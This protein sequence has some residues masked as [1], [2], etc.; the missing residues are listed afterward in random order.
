ML[1]PNTPLRMDVSALRAATDHID[2]YQE[3]IYAAACWYAN[4]GFHIVPFR[5]GNKEGKY[6]GFPKVDP[7]DQSEEPEKLSPA[8]ATCNPNT[9]RRWWHP[10]EGQY[11]GAG[12]AMAHGGASGLCALDLDIDPDKDIDGPSTLAD[13]HAAY[14]GNWDDMDTEDAIETLAAT[15]PSGGRHLVFRYHPE[16]GTDAN[17]VYEGIDTRGGRKDSPAENG[18][19]TF[20]E[21]TR[22]PGK[23]GHYRWDKDS[24]D[25]MDPPQWLVDVLNG[26]KPA[27]G[28]VKLPDSFTEGNRDA[29]INKALMSFVGAGYTEEQLWALEPDIL[30]RMDPPDPKMVKDK[31]KSVL[32]SRIFKKAQEEADIAEQVSGI[33]LSLDQK[34]KPTKDP[35]NLKAIL[36]SAYFEYDYG[37]VRFDAF[38]QQT[39]K[40]GISMASRSDWAVGIRHWISHRIKT[41]CWSPD[42]IRREIE[43]LVENDFPHINTARDYML[44]CPAPA[45]PVEE[46]FN[47]SGRAGPGPAFRRLCTEV[48]DLSNPDL[49][50]GYDEKTRHAYEGFLWVWLQGAAARACVPGCKMDVVLNLFGKQGIRKSSFFGRLC[51]DERWFTDQVTEAVV[52]SFASKDELAKLHAKIIVEMAE[53]S[54]VKK[55]GKSADD[56][57]KQFISAQSDRMRAPYGK[58]TLDYPRTCAFAG[59]SNNRDVYRDATGSRRF[60]SIDHGDKPIRASLLEEFRDELWGEVVHSFAYGELHPNNSRNLEVAVPESLWEAQNEVNDSHKYEDVGI[61]DV[62]DWMRDKTR[63]TWREVID[64]ARTVPGLRDEKE[65]VLMTR[66]RSVLSNDAAFALRKNGR[67]T[68]AA[69][70]NEKP[71]KM[72]INVSHELEKDRSAHDPVPPHWSAYTGDK[73]EY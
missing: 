17:A 45:A 58:D 39:T 59:T 43:Y 31:I 68:D 32:K 72:W 52:A 28:K 16:V 8:H 21:P 47:G 29:G 41:Y 23:N 15:T 10:F 37:C 60:I 4:N 33:S 35:L 48:L 11:P 61:S 57:L 38:T 36:K 56:R 25:I 55:G 44:A 71:S 3:K 54:P 46:N 27:R 26:R 12:I 6:K 9:I 2:D 42:E 20:V 22:K 69:G 63:I 30:A 64:H 1:R 7:H 40:N 5:M 18:G 34:G 65:S 53:L 50:P 14:A 70:N 51:P 19:I 66:I 13:L 62:V 49:H 67:R 24:P 73:D